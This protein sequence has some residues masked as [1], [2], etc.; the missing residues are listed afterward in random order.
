VPQEFGLKVCIL[1]DR[2]GFILH[3][4]V[5]GKQTDDQVAVEMVTAGKEKFPLLTVCSFDK[6]FH[7]PRNQ[8]DLA[9]KLDKIALPRKGRL[10]PESK[11]IEHTEDFV[12]ARRRHS[13]VESGINA[14]E[15]HGLD[16]CPDP[17]LNGF[18][19]YVSLAVLA[20]NIQI[21]GSMVQKKEQERLHR[22]NEAALK[23]PRLAA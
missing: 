15:N 17:G 6:G 14:L 12:Q 20:R 13:A 1:E 4:K 16:R 5:M 23:R 11:A 18:K 21:L 19:R 8:K 3:H 7:S 22:E 10:S 9:E 2:Y